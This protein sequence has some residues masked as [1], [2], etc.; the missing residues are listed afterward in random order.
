MMPIITSKVET[1]VLYFVIKEKSWNKLP[2][3][4]Q[5]WDYILREAFLVDVKKNNSNL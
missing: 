1:I 5:T 2:K 3:R 4:A